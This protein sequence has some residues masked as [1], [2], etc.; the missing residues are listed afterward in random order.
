M[1]KKE[2]AIAAKL[3]QMARD[4]FGDHGCNDL[5]SD[6]W[7]GWTIDERK[8]FI[9]EYH[10]YNGD[11]EEFDE[12]YLHLPDYAVMGFMAHKLRLEAENE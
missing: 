1:N 4:E 10:E 7:D 11:P 6:F 3:M 9:R 5:D 8:Q 12:N 2:K